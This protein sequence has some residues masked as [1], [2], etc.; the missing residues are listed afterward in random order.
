M[1]VFGNTP[2]HKF[3]EAGDSGHNCR[4]NLLHVAAEL[5]DAF[6]EIDLRADHDWKELPGQMFIRMAERQKREK[7]LIRKANF[8]QGILGTPAVMQQ[9]FVM[10]HHAFGHAAGTRRIDND[11]RVLTADP[12]GALSDVIRTLAAPSKKFIPRKD[13]NT[14][15][16]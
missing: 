10:Q 15:R 9:R 11:G 1:D 3:I 12:S 8:K 6:R 16:L 13:L 2:M 4:V 7:H 5:I 14:T